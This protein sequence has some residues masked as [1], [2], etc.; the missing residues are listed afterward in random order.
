MSYFGM[1][2]N[3]TGNNVQFYTGSEEDREKLKAFSDD[4]KQFGLIFQVKSPV[5]EIPED[6]TLVQASERKAKEK[7]EADALFR[8]ANNSPRYLRSYIREFV[9]IY[10]VPVRKVMSS[11]ISAFF[12]SNVHMGG[13]TAQKDNAFDIIMTP[14][15]FTERTGKEIGVDQVIVAS[16]TMTIFLKIALFGEA[17]QLMME[18]IA[19]HGDENIYVTMKGEEVAAF[20]RNPNSKHVQFAY[21]VMQTWMASGKKIALV[22]K[23]ENKLK[24]P[25]STQWV[26]ILD[27]LLKMDNPDYLDEVDVDAELRNTRVRAFFDGLFAEGCITVEDNDHDGTPQLYIVMPREIYP[28]YFG[29]LK[30]PYLLIS[31]SA[32]VKML[33]FA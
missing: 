25:H 6:E 18:E 13:W 27:T 8:I 2:M 24:S 28:R 30:C 23:T 33:D 17:Q 12:A 31:K 16:D 7:A 22:S 3:E 32:L 9:G 10:P 26:T 19:S 20:C 21:D 15:F 5:P 4:V 29:R 14:K 1:C 11:M